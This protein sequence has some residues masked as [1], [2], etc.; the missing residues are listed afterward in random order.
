MSRTRNRRTGDNSGSMSTVRGVE[1]TGSRLSLIHSVLEQEP[2]FSQR[3]QR[4]ARKRP[5]LQQNTPPHKAILPFS[6][7]PHIKEDTRI[8]ETVVVHVRQMRSGEIQNQFH[9]R[10]SCDSS[11][12][13]ARPSALPMSPKAPKE[14]MRWAR[15]LTIFFLF[16]AFAE[17]VINCL[18]FAPR[19][20][21]ALPF[22]RPSVR[23]KDRAKC[24]TAALRRL[25][26]HRR[27]NW[28]T[29]TPNCIGGTALPFRT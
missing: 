25:A 11:P 24:A 18:R 1:K 22:G 9:F 17:H 15:L 26:N 14:D 3:H 21:I 29:R 12:I 13:F 8:R 16:S 23:R 6:L 28:P 10:H 2:K 4:M 7:L 27:F 19:P 20:K 5:P